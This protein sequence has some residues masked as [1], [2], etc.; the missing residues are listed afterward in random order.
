MASK[1]VQKASKQSYKTI[2]ST[3][4]HIY[5]RGGQIFC[6]KILG[7]GQ[8]FC[9]KNQGGVHRFCAKNLG[10]VADFARPKK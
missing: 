3:L 10:G 5:F 8:R 9:T 7:G 6:T 4:D 1:S 2:I